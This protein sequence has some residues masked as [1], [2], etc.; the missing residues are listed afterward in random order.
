MQKACKNIEN[1]KSSMILKNQDYHV[2]LLQISLRYPT[3]NGLEGLGDGY[4]FGDRISKFQLW[5]VLY[6]VWLDQDG[7][8][9]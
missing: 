9:C 8:I 6:V 3:H 2:A 7:K 5:S 1:N 4:V